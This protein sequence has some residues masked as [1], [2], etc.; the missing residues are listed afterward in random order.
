MDVLEYRDQFWFYFT[1]NKIEAQLAKINKTSKEELQS[2]VTLA[3]DP[4]ET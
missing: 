1:T 3:D 4:M 2:N